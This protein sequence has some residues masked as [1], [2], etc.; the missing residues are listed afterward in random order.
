MSISWRL[1]GL[2]ACDKGR[3]KWRFDVFVSASAG[4]IDSPLAPWLNMGHRF[5]SGV[6]IID[7]AVPN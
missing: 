7:F 6:E 4:L 3:K 5:N 2:T 1:I